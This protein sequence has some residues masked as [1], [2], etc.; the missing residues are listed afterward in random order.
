M[1]VYRDREIVTLEQ[2]KAIVQLHEEADISRAVG[3]THEIELTFTR[4]R[5]GGRH[6][7]VKDKTDVSMCYHVSRKGNA[8]QCDGT[9]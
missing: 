5:K 7:Y 2:L 6:L 1:P 4:S 3:A 9:P 8:L